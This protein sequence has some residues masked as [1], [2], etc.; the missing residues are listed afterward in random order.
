LEPFPANCSQVRVCLY[1]DHPIP[2]LQ[3]EGRVFALVHSYVEDKVIFHV[4]LAHCVATRTGIAGWVLVGTVL[5]L[6][7]A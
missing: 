7:P 4:Q 1:G 5:N 3:V 2:L 6:T